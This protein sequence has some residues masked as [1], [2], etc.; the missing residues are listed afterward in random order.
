MISVGR[1]TWL[2]CKR[3]RRAFLKRDCPSSRVLVPAG[4][5]RYTVTKMYHLCLLEP[6]LFRF[7]HDAPRSEL[8][9]DLALNFFMTLR[10][11]LVLE[12]EY[13]KRTN[14]RGVTGVTKPTQTPFIFLG[15]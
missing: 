6:A 5:C 11:H 2:G 1:K 12:V 4:G 15:I 13:Y 7:L 3:R 9:I 10:G 8:L 14:T